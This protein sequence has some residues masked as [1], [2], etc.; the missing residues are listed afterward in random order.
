MRIIRSVRQ[1]GHDY[2][3]VRRCLSILRLVTPASRVVVAEQLG[4]YVRD[5]HSL[6]E[7]ANRAPLVSFR[8]VL[9]GGNVSRNERNTSPIVGSV[10][11]LSI[12]WRRSSAMAACSRT[13]VPAFAQLE[14]R[15]QLCP[16]S[17]TAAPSAHRGTGQSDRSG[18]SVEAGSSAGSISGSCCSRMLGTGQMVPTVHHSPES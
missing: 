12:G 2:S 17:A 8:S 14:G 5:N 6:P 11:N 9:L 18:C 3:R 4:G 15:L 16:P 10:A 7:G 1:R 13:H